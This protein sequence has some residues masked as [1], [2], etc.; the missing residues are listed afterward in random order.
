MLPGDP[1]IYIYDNDNGNNIVLNMTRSIGHWGSC[2]ISTEP[3]IT[4]ITWPSGNRA[5]LL[6]GTDGYFNCLTKENQLNEL[7]FDF[8]PQDIC[9]RGY[10]AV[11]DTFGY[12]N[13]DNMTICIC[14][15]I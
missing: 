10:K 8:T 5:R 13:G 1:A 12:N 9:E 15:I 3:D 11:G 4:R 2:F 6:V 7:S 14:E